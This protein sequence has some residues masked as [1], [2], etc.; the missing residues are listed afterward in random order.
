M[1]T[2]IKSKNIGME[3][4]YYPTQLLLPKKIRDPLAREAA[5]IGLTPN[6]FVRTLVM[7]D[8]SDKKL[9]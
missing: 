2:P 3:R 9:I 6:V 1:D 4:D 5:R 7:K 8:L